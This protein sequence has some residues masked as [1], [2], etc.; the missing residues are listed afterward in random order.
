LKGFIMAAGSPVKMNNA[1]PT[2]TQRGTVL[3]APAF[4][5]IGG[6]PTQA[7]F[8]DLLGRLRTA[9]VIAS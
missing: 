1:L 6:A 3:Q 8:N 9:G 4:A 5:N 2:T 7:N